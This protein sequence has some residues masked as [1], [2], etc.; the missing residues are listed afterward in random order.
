MELC[1]KT[2]AER[3]STLREVLCKM[4]FTDKLILLVE[5]YY[6]YVS[7]T[8]ADKTIRPVRLPYIAEPYD[9]L[10]KRPFKRKYRKTTKPKAV[11]G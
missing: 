4:S 8:F 6:C 7:P 11:K 9:A 10:H 3:R 2:E 1:V 5:C